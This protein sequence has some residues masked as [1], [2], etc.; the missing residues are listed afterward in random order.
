MP[1]DLNTAR[2]HLE[3][4]DLGTLPRRSLVALA[5]GRPDLVIPAS[6]GDRRP[7]SRIHGPNPPVTQG[8]LS[9]RKSC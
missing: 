4:R 8:D 5:A 7:K 2:G 1:N 6:T 3:Y 9:P